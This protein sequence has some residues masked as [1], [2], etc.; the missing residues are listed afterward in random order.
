MN[1]PF[2]IETSPFKVTLVDTWV[3]SPIETPCSIR[4]KLLIIE[5]FQ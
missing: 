3:L 4:Q 2:P 1:V 5:F